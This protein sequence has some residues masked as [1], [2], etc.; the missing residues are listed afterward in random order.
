[1]GRLKRYRY[2]NVKLDGKLVDQIREFGANKGI[3]NFRKASREYADHMEI[4]KW[5]IKKV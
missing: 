5:R 1:M 4:L 2:Q 3:K